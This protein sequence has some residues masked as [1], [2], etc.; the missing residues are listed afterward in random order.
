MEEM[1]AAEET[2]DEE[3]ND[4][5]TDYVAILENE[6]EEVG[7]DSADFDYFNAEPQKRKRKAEGP[8]CF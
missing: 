3:T 2:D 5:K 8:S 1:D 7:I 4:E 6:F